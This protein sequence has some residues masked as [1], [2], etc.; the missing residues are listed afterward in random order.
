MGKIK[1]YCKDI[2]YIM[3]LCDSCH[4]RIDKD[5][6]ENYP[7]TLLKKIKKEHEEFIERIVLCKNTTET[8]AIICCSKIGEYCPPPFDNNMLI[9][10]IL[11]NG[12]RPAGNEPILPR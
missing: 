8:Q 1:K 10:A 9:E 5:E 6:P 4:K 11:R 12:K 2:D 7:V 3:L